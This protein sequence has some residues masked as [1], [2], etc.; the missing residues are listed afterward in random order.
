MTDNKADWSWVPQRE[1]EWREGSLV[2]G[3]H[4]N[5][6]KLVWWS[7]PFGPTGYMFENGVEQAFQDF[8]VSGP[9]VSAPPLVLDELE[10]LLR[11]RTS[12]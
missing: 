6:G 12:G 10:A 9:L 11:R 4:T 1:W 3:V 5:E 7:R 8:L 2:R